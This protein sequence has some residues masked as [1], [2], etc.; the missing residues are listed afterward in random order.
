MTSVYLRFAT[1]IPVRKILL[2]SFLLSLPLL[3][4]PAV[5]LAEPFIDAVHHEFAAQIE[6]LHGKGIVR[7]YA[8]AIFHPDY[9]INR[10]EFLTILLRSLPLSTPL[11]TT[12]AHCFRDF[13]GQ[14]RWFWKTACTARAMGIVQGYPNGTFG[15]A[16]TITSIEAIKMLIQAFHIPLP[17]F[18]RAP[19]HWYD[20]YVDAAG[21]RGVFTVIPHILTHTLT[22]G[23]MAA[24]IVLLAPTLPDRSISS[25]G[26][27]DSSSSA[28]SS[29]SISS[30]RCAAGTPL[31]SLRF[32][33]ARGR[34]V[35]LR[36]EQSTRD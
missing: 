30:V 8:H 22:R 12:D 15:G 13:T 16:K 6:V 28:S 27:S 10:A 32:H 14:E 26:S 19:A 20:P 18:I 29:S 25:S 2:A 11:P 9:P 33:R 36:L 5:G 35:V 24:L 17:T 31:P 4:V 23:D 7:G 21:D 34:Y 1:L 3:A